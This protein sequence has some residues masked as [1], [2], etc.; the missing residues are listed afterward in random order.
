M[1][2]LSR[3]LLKTRPQ[4]I[5]EVMQLLHYK[6]GQADSQIVAFGGDLLVDAT[7]TKFATTD[8]VAVLAQ[9]LVDKSAQTAIVV[10][11]GTDTAAGQF[12]KVLVQMDASGTISQKSGALSTTTQA[13]AVKPAPDTD[14]ISLGWL[15]L[16]ASFVP[17]TTVLT[18]AM[19]KKEPYW[20][21]TANLSP[22][23]NGR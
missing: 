20:T 19:L 21:W 1:P 22:G 10:L 9:G 7:T 12:R 11:A 8:L 13:D 6:A 2:S 15:E 17:G 14:K 5:S 4:R 18:T 16:P 3:D 23:N